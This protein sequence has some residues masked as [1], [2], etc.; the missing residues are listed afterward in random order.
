MEI[1]ENYDKM[2]EHLKNQHG[3]QLF[4]LTQM[5]KANRIAYNIMPPVSTG[6]TDEGKKGSALGDKEGDELP[7]S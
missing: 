5:V 2:Y 6:G 1:I 3:I 4:G 7:E